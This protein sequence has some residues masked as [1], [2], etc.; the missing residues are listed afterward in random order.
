MCSSPSR[1]LAAWSCAVRSRFVESPL[2]SSASAE[3]TLHLL[4][5]LTCRRGV[6]QMR[7]D[8]A[9]A[10]RLEPESSPWRPA[11]LM[12]HGVGNLIAGDA[13]TAD[14]L[15]AEAVEA[16]ERIEAF[17]SSSV[18]LAERALVAMGR[19]DWIAAEALARRARVTVERGRLETCAPSSIVFAV[20]ARVALRGGD[21]R[22]ARLEVIR[23]HRLRPMLTRAIPWLAA[24][25]MIELAR[26][27]L[28]LS[29]R[30]GAWTLLSDAHDIVAGLP[31]LGA[32][33]DQIADL[34][35]RLGQ[36][37][38]V[39]VPGPTSLTAAELRLLSY[40]PT[41]LSFR[42]IGERFH[43][44][45]NTIKTQAIS[46]YR[47]LSVSARTD[48]VLRARDIGLLDDQPGPSAAGRAG[49]AASAGRRRARLSRMPLSVSSQ[50]GNTT[51]RAG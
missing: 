6:E 1:G 21:V 32:L 18:A 28:A 43:L 16:A 50:T 34:R 5:A 30:A 37:Q 25:T 45:P 38:G 49:S 46:I 29:D 24:Q 27:Q 36:V 31:D 12:L 3:S 26:V 17:P 2:D 11:A 42:E 51:T 9:A 48:A 7:D 47:K 10:F 14:G 35:R 22:R 15:L 39:G 44:S 13:D 20:L 23:A 41:H 33:G 19:D 40:L 8:A 4:R